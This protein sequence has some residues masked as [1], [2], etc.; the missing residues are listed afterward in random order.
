M[1]SVVLIYLVLETKDNIHA[2]YL[3][4]KNSQSDYAVLEAYKKLKIKFK[5]IL[6]NRGS[7]ERQFNSPGI[8]LPITSI[9][10]TKY[11][12]FPEYHTSLDNFKLVTQK[13]LKEVL[14]F[15]KTAIEILLNKVIPKNQILC[16]PFMEKRKFIKISI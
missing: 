13:V 5:N 6:L 14:Q 16:E 10:R 3:K 11:G 8:D 12:E 9:F 15:Q 2:C 1:L 4:K 7:D